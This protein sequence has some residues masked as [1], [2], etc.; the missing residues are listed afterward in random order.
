VRA[1]ADPRRRLSILLR[2][3]IGATTVLLHER[4]STEAVLLGLDDATIVSLVPTTLARLLDAGLREPP[5]LRWAL[6]GG[7]P[8]PP[9]LLDRAREAR[10]P[11]AP[12]YGLTE[13]CSQ[14]TTNGVALFCTRV[15]LAADGEILVSGP[16]ISPSHPGALATGDLGSFGAD[17]R[18]HV[19]GRKADTIVTGGE[20]V[21]PAEVE[22]VLEAHPDVAEA[23]VLGRPD[24]EWGEAVVALVVLRDGAHATEQ[25]LRDHAAGRL[26]RFKVPEGGHG[27]Q[28]TASANRIGQ[29]P[30]PSAVTADFL[31]DFNSPYAY[32]AAQRVDDVMPVEV[33]WRPIAFGVLIRQIG[34]VPWS[35]SE[36]G[37]RRGRQAR[38]RAARRRGRPAAAAL[39]RGAGP[40]A[41]TRCCRCAAAVVASSPRPPQALLAGRLPARTSSTDAL[42]ATS[43]SS[44]RPAGGGRRRGRDPRGRRGPAGQGRPCA[45]G[46]TRRSPRAV[47]G[48][49]T[50]RACPADEHFWATTAWRTPRSG[51]LT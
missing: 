15:E 12:T 8:I 3:A 38:L 29:A 5:A 25:E 6:L 24:D 50:S 28:R 42:C 45:T 41:T 37:D 43:T 22:A 17:G 33:R 7:A 21:A 19:T 10:V 30:A 35:L 14:V 32:L 4:W 44:P 23:A 13:A 51:A 31:Y 48:I 47:T 20:N 40:R 26:E 2:S 49:P 9:A 34:K 46:P 27:P 36:A 1:A 16:T 18:L 39:G 11:V